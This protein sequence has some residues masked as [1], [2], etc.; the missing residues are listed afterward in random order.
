MKPVRQSQ[1][2]T[3]GLS[4]ASRYGFVSRIP[5]PRGSVGAAVANEAVTRVKADLA[6]VERIKDLAEFS[7]VFNTITRGAK[8]DISVDLK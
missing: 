1:G 7:P 2:S 5:R 3:A 6:D 4:A 8:V